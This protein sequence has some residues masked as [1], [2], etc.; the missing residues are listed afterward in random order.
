MRLITGN[1]LFKTTPKHKN[2]HLIFGRLYKYIH[3]YIVS[4]CFKNKNV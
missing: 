3:R 4:F 2:V 1:K